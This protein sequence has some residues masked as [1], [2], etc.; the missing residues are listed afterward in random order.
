MSFYDALTTFYNIL[1]YAINY[2]VPVKCYYKSNFPIWYSDELKD[3]TIK[4]RFTHAMYKKTGICSHYV[5]FSSL[6]AKCKSLSRKCY[7]EYIDLVESNIHYDINHFWKFTSKIKSDKNNLPKVMFLDNQCCDN[8]CDIA[9]LFA[10]YFSSIFNNNSINCNKP[11]FNSSLSISN[12]IIDISSLLNKLVSIKSSTSPSFD[13]IPSCLLKNC[14]NN[15]A[16]ALTFLFNFSLS[17]GIVPDVWKVSFVNPVFKCGSRDNVKNYRPISMLCPIAKVFDSLVYD[18]IYPLTSSIIPE[19]H[20]FVKNRST[21]TN[22]LIYQTTI[23]NA[24]NENFIVD[25]IHTDFSKAFDSVNISTVLLK[26]ETYGIHG[27]LLK[28][29]SS[30]LADRLQIVKAN[31]SYSFA[32]PATSGVPQGSHL[33]PLLFLVF[34]NDIGSIFNNVFFLLFA[35]D[36]KIFKVIK[37][38]HDNHILQNN[39]DS[40]QVWCSNN[41][42]HLNVSK[43]YQICCTK[44]FN[45]VSN[46][47]Q[48]KLNDQYLTKVEIIKDLGVYFDS[49][50]SFKYHIL[51][52]FSKALKVLGFVIRFSRSFHSISTLK[53]LYITLVRPI[54]EFSSLIWSPNYQYLISHIEKIQHRFLRY[55]YFFE[56]RQYSYNIDYNQI[57]STVNMST[58]ESRRLKADLIFLFK[59]INNRIDCNVI[60][61]LLNFNVPSHRTL[62]SLFSLMY[63]SAK[64]IICIFPQ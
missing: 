10:T 53:L 18:L 49:K 20:G 30:Y 23:F 48:Y 43:C 40:L 1:S 17:Y 3:L 41:G 26:L 45:S 44:K 57:L 29:F 61:E 62:E 6:R 7:H 19:Q 12:I 32:F 39:L 63:H 36:L 14:A 35:D 33:G 8:D 46:Y 52:I 2:F 15:L 25:S 31:S 60:L 24:C 55:I 4:K 13:G 11:S 50:L 56:N 42:L 37:S 47:F 16:E 54:L 64:P 28:W 59:I 21:T 58:L 27:S 51:Q 5:K 38:P 34:I 9:N 22:L